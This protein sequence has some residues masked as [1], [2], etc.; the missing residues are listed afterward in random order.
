M[1][2][3]IL[4]NLRLEFIKTGAV[5]FN[6]FLIINVLI[7]QHVHHT[8][9]EGYIASHLDGHIER[10][11]IDQW[12]SPRVNNDELCAIKYGIFK[13]SG[14]HRMGLGHICPYTEEHPGLAKLSKRIGHCAGTKRCRQ[15]GD[16][17]SVSG[18]GTVIYV[19]RSDHRTEEFLH[20]IGIFVQAA[21]ATNPCYGVRAML[22]DYLLEFIGHKI[23]GLV[24]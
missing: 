20:L 16:R 22:R 8:V 23:E 21:G 5:I 14:G 10:G 7:Y 6:E 2:W 24:P 13:E 15:T 9:K 11:K 1:L 12:L 18:P 4:H 17:W 3:G 19:I